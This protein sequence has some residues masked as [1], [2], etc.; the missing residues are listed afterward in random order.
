MHFYQ[1]YPGS[2]ALFYCILSGSTQFVNL[3]HLVKEV[4]ITFSTLNHSFFPVYSICILFDGI[5]IHVN[6]TLLS[7][8]WPIDLASID[9]LWLN[10]F[11]KG[12]QMLIF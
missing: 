1:E 2:D 7:K 8:H 3:H 4:F 9:I 11:K 6:I 10:Y 5:W 12:F